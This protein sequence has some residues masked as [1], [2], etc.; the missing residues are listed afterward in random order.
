MSGAG[1]LIK[2]FCLDL[3]DFA[4]L[5][6]PGLVLD[7]PL[8]PSSFDGINKGALCAISTSSNRAP[9][10]VGHTTMSAYDM[11]MSAGRG[12]V[13]SI[14]HVLGDH[15]CSLGSPLS[16]PILNSIVKTPTQDDT[17][18]VETDLD[19][20][21]H[22]T[23]LSTEFI[24]ASNT[25]HPD[26][27][28]ALSSY[29]DSGIDLLPGDR[30]S[31]LQYANGIALL[32]E[33]PGYDV[34]LRNFLLLGIKTVQDNQLPMPVNVFYANH[35]L[36]QKYVRS[37]HHVFETISFFIILFFIQTLSRTQYHSNHG[38]YRY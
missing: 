11:F 29:E 10:A 31:D 17:S 38:C 18:P 7:K 8:T 19:P 13:V 28:E 3:F 15:I 16:R 9:V 36:S 34:L 1:D 4:D 2:A 33:N 25:K 24:E 26:N 35:V 27:K 5:M 32:S 20:Q 37:P 22:A 21:L 23:G 6:L 12:K 14:F 30:L